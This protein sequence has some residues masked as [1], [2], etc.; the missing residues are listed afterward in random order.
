MHL[1]EV[2]GAA[3]AVRVEDELGDGA[4]RDERGR[5]ADGG[6]SAAARVVVPAGPD[7]VRV[8]RVAWPGQPTRVGVR[9]A[10]GVAVGDPHAD[11]GAGR[12]AVEDASA[13]LR[14]TVPKA[15]PVHSHQTKS[16]S[17]GKTRRPKR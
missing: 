2:C 7:G 16:L 13:G 4:R 8:V 14:P 6:M 5:E 3:D 12:A 15:A 17:R 10:V 11:G 9:L 1:H